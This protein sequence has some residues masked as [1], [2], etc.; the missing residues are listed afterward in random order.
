[1]LW[2]VRAARLLG[3]GIS[4]DGK[5]SRS[6]SAAN[7]AEFTGSALAVQVVGIPELFENG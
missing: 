1:M 7:V 5:R 4:I 2:D 6:R 3:H